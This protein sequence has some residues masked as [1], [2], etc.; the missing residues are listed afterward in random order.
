MCKLEIKIQM[1]NINNTDD[2]EQNQL[3]RLNTGN[4]GIKVG[5]MTSSQCL[6]SAREISQDTT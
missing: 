6:I 2:E 3:S 5:K 4:N 1:K